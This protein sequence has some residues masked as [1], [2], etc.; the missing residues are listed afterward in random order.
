MAFGQIQPLTLPTGTLDAEKCKVLVTVVGEAPQ[1]E[2]S[3]DNPGG[4][5][6]L[7]GLGL[8]VFLQKGTVALLEDVWGLSVLFTFLKI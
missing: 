8:G 7:I 2:V 5:T 1:L 6:D 4:P 3:Q